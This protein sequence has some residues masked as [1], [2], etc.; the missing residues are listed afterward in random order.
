VR[1]L[2]TAGPTREPLDP[3]RYL[4]NR[5]TGA[6]G[7]ALAESALTA[8]H[9]VTLVLGPVA[10]AAPTKADIV[11]VE[12]TE[13]MLSAVLE[14]LPHAD[15]VICAA[16]VSDYRPAQRSER[17]LKRGELN[18]IELVENPDIAVA[19]GELRQDRPHIVFALE[20]D[21]P[22]ENARKKIVK[23]NA[24]LCVLNSP[25]AIGASRAC[26]TLVHPDGKVHELGEIEKR[27]LFQH[28][29]LS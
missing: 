28:L 26:F 11:N 18:S 24:T 7:T 6:M 9:A 29:E 16:A 27:D 19:V 20:S 25:A 17:K 2:I 22:V 10:G 13:E 8:G 3:V 4:S 1:I 14:H 5:S 12:T 23:K 21:N 15:A